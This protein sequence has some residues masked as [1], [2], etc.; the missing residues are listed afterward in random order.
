MKYSGVVVPMV[1]PVKSGSVDQGAVRTIVDTFAAA[2]VDALVMGTTGEGNSVSRDDA[3]R[4]IATAVRQSEGRSVIYAGLTGNCV[5]EQYRQTEMMA[6][7]GAAAVVAVVP[8]Y[9]ALSDE[10]IAIYYSS[11]ADRSPLPVVIY[12]IP[13][14]THISIPIEVV[15]QLSHHPNIVAIKDSERDEERMKRSIAIAHA[16]DNFSFFCGWAAK[17]AASL[18]AGADGIVP[19]TANLTP[20][21]FRSLYDAALKGDTAAADRWQATTDRIARIYQSGRVLGGQLAAL[22][23]LMCHAGLCTT[24]MLP[25]LTALSPSE[26]TAVVTEFNNLKNE[27]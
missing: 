1:T 15:A 10:Q 17:S 16:N 23:T 8:S 14:T 3:Q 11:L 25:P 6:K 5:E 9:Y 12:N 21:M 18:A 2:R 20:S 22:K 26:Q 7:A 13:S 27:I 19:S 4:L 24:E